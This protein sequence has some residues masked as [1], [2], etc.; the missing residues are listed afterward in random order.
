MDALTL[1]VVVPLLAAGIIVLLGVLLMMNAVAVFIRQ[2]A[3]R[4]IRW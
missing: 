1:L 2:R 4:N 3:Q